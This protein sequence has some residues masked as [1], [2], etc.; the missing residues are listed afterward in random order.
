VLFTSGF[1]GTLPSNDPASDV[2]DA[3]LSK[4]YRKFELATAV[5]KSLLGA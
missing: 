1:P 5:R 2:A 4:P 3:L